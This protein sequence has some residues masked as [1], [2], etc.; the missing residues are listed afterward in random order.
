MRFFLFAE[1]STPSAVVRHT[2]A[3][4]IKAFIINFRHFVFYPENTGQSAQGIGLAGYPVDF[5]FQFR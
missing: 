5:L 2:I 1:N 4:R 3:T